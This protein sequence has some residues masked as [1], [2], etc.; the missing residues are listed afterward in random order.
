MKYTIEAA[1]KLYTDGVRKVRVLLENGSKR[2]LRLSRSASGSVMYISKGKR[3]WGMHLYELH[4]LDIS[5][6]VSRKSPEA[7]WLDGWK[8]V[9]ARL[10]LSG[11]WENISKDI[12]VA[13]AV[14]FDKMNQACKEY[15]ELQRLPD[16]H[17]D[18][19]V[20]SVKYP[21]LISTNDKG[22]T[23]INTS[24]LWMLAKLP[25]VKKMVIDGSKTHN[26]WMLQRIQ[27]AMNKK[28]K[29]SVSGRTSYDTSFEYNPEINRAWFSEEFKGCGNGHYFLALDATHVLFYEDD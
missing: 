16:G 6:I 19:S 17:Q 11:L 28:E 29:I 12:D 25:K 14:G 26:T 3:R 23:F 8:K 27:D 21:E 7:K 1:E 2:N 24:L 10:I 15:Q 13:L 20:F 5:P 22:K 4:P 18:I 9:K